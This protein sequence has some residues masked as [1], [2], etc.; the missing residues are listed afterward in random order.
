MRSSIPWIAPIEG[1]GITAPF[2]RQWKTKTE[3]QAVDGLAVSRAMDRQGG[4]NGQWKG[5]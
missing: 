5:R 2:R 1:F 3:E 4:D